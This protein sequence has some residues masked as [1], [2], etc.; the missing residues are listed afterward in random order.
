M[1][2]SDLYNQ[3][4]ISSDNV[5]SEYIHGIHL[6]NTFFE[7]FYGRNA[8]SIKHVKKDCVSFLYRFMEHTISEASHDNEYGFKIKVFS[9]N[10]NKFAF[11]FFYGEYYGDYELYVTDEAILN[12]LRDWLNDI[13]VLEKKTIDVVDTSEDFSYYLNRAMDSNPNYGY[14]IYTNGTVEINSGD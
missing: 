8:S 11:G 6:Q 1:K 5:L 14:K 2:I 9:Y 3:S 13:F 10:G 7:D 12:L 4:Y